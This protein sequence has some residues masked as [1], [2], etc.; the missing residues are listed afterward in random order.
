MDPLEMIERAEQKISSWDKRCTTLCKLSPTLRGGFVLSI[1]LI[2]G[3]GLA[4]AWFSWIKPLPYGWGHFLWVLFLFPLGV[5][6]ILAKL[7]YDRRFKPRWMLNPI[8]YS[9]LWWFVAGGQ[10]FSHGL[11]IWEAG[12]RPLASLSWALLLILTLLYG[13]KIQLELKRRR[14]QSAHLA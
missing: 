4:L 14:S 8:V 5:I 3:V 6:L 9:G 1:A 2:L 12:N 13:A 10:L 11:N 7:P